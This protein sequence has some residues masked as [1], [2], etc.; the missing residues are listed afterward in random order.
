M[1]VAIEPI[2]A[3]ESDDVVYGELNDWN[4]YCRK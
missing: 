3:I 4:L 1:V 2:T